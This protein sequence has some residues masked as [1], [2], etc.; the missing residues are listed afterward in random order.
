MHSNDEHV[1]VYTF[2]KNLEQCYGIL[3]H[4]MDFANTRKGFI[5]GPIW[6]MYLINEKK[7]K[8]WLVSSEIEYFHVYV[9]IRHIEKC[10]FIYKEQKSI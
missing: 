5:T 7:V 1:A 3:Y 2:Y 6:Y 8:V 9:Y 4:H 10:T